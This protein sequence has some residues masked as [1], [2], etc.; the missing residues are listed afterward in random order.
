[1]PGAQTQDL[2]WVLVMS[3]RNLSQAQAHES[4]PVCLV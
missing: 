3:A 1:M 4:R 2:T